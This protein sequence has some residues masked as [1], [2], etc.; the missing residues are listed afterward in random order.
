MAYSELKRLA[1]AIRGRDPSAT[2]TPTVLVHEAWLKLSKSLNLVPDS[3]AHFIGMAARAM[4][5]LL[6]E[7]A[8]RRNT[9]KRSPGEAQPFVHLPGAQKQTATV[10]QFLALDEA[11][12]ELGAANPRQASI[13]EL[14]YFGGLTVTEIAA[15]LGV[16]ETTVEREW[17]VA[18]AYLALRLRP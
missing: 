12:T 3:R 7:A 13:V 14:R 15:E 10:E 8:R 17:R 5:Q 16:S 1:G 11:L 2:L 18:R 9:Q 6:V 4:R